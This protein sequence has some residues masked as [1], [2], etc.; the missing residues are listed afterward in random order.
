MPTPLTPEELIALKLWQVRSVS[1][2]ITAVLMFGLMLIT[3]NVNNVPGWQ[4]FLLVIA[5]LGLALAGAVQHSQLRCPRCGAKIG[6]Q[7]KLLLPRACKS[8]GVAFK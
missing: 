5:I 1:L 4:K 2:F 8:C 3:S 6:R 7:T